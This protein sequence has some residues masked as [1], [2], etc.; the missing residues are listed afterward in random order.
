[1]F[2]FVNVLC[3]VVVLGS[4]NNIISIV[5][6]R[7]GKRC[8]SR[9]CGIY[10]WSLSLNDLFLL[11]ILGPEFAL[12]KSGY[13]LR[14][15]YTFI[16]KFIRFGGHVFPQISAWITVAIAVERMLYV[17]FPITMYRSRVKVRQ[18]I[19]IGLIVLL[20]IIL[21]INMLITLDIRT[22]SGRNGTVVQYC[23]GDAALS[24][25][26]AILSGISYGVFTF[27]LPL[28]VLTTSNCV[29]LT[30]LC[31]SRR[32]ARHRQRNVE[33]ISKLVICISVLHCVSTFPYAL[34]QYG[35]YVGLT[36][37][38]SPV[39]VDYIYISYLINSGCNFVLYGLF[40]Q[41]FRKDLK[42]LL[43][44]SVAQCRLFCNCCQTS[45][46]NPAS[47]T[48]ISVMDFRETIHNTMERKETIFC[49]RTSAE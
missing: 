1:M 37:I 22:F 34:Y 6:W 49:T 29:T 45:V 38:Y 47:T 3:L 13:K 35:F 11:L 39:A 8:K 12:F 4:I 32:N 15:E 26:Y 44:S 5:V 36:V 18:A 48:G 20:S 31:K 40:N 41:D 16:C 14:N 7:R 2:S 9:S 10:M 43:M 46:C 19:V 30:A 17:C 21:N 33:N 25:E 28:I 27:L 23:S 42:E 24:S